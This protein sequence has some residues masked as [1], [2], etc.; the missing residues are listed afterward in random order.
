MP[1]MRGRL[2]SSFL[3]HFFGEYVGVGFTA[4]LEVRAA[5]RARRPAP[6]C[7]ATRRDGTLLHWNT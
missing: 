5:P 6:P 3:E 7:D 1:E 4:S 2:V